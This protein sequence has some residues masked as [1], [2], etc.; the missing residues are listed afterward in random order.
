MSGSVLIWSSMLSAAAALNVAVWVLSAAVLGRRKAAW[1]AEVYRAR[2]ALLWLS[3][4][5]VLGCAFR[6]VLPMVDAPRICVH[7]SFASYIAI[8][9]SVAT[10]A[11]LCFAA[12]WM[13]VL[14]EAGEAAGGRLATFV[15]RMVMPLIIVA[16]LFSW[17]ATLTTNYLLHAVENSLWT[18]TAVL[19][20]AAFGSL[21]ARFGEWR[22][23]ILAAAIV[24]GVA[25]VAFMTL[26]DVPM[27]LARWQA[28]LAAGRELLPLGEGLRE[29]IRRCTVTRD[30]AAWREDV[31]WLTLYF[32]VAVWISIALAHLPAFAREAVAP[33]EATRS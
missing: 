31:P 7:D 5:Y 16:E 11:E 6:S 2:R 3:A 33:S 12:Q 18:L 17:G 22:R 32:T 8:G 4:V 10:V 15:S 24:C 14:R 21:R 26:V 13:L 28:D 25:Y 19:A 30:W 9:R 20:I 1:P 27:Y 23:S 29:V